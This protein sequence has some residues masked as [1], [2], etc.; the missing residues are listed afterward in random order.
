MHMTRAPCISMVDCSKL[1]RHLQIPFVV[2][3]RIAPCD[4]L[5]SMTWIVW[6]DSDNS[7]TIFVPKFKPFIARPYSRICGCS[8]AFARPLAL[9]H[10]LLC[11]IAR[12]QFILWPQW[13]SFPKKKKKEYSCYSSVHWNT[14]LF[15]RFYSFWAVLYICCCVTNIAKHSLGYYS[16]ML[17]KFP[18]NLWLQTKLVSCQINMHQILRSS[19]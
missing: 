7:F 6:H 8:R 16:C 11:R 10:L 2:S 15:Q 18:V 5:F 9:W 12:L 1:T 17:C 13:L 14:N 19:D 3:I 4:A